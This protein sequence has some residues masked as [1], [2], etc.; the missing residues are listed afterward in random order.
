MT[1]EPIC[2]L[3]NGPVDVIS[4]DD[5]SFVLSCPQCD[6]IYGVDVDATDPNYPVYWPRF[7]IA[8]KGDCLP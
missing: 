3:C 7:R 2:C 4:A 1:D 5:G 8:L 6:L